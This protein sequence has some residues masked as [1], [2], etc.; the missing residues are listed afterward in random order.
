MFETIHEFASDF[1][2]YSIHA[3]IVAANQDKHTHAHRNSC[4]VW[5]CAYHNTSRLAN[6]TAFVPPSFASGSCLIPLCAASYALR[7]ICSP[8]L[9]ALQIF[10]VACAQHTLLLKHASKILAAETDRC[11]PRSHASTPAR[12][13]FANCKISAI[14]SCR[15]AVSSTIGAQKP[16]QAG[17]PP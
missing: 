10:L 2:S 4:A 7:S 14:L 16:E 11:V 5:L 13:D 1:K 15:H 9:C 12:P 3:T 8:M 17:N 6:L